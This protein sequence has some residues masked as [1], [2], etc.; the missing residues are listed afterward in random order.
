MDGKTCIR[1]FN[2]RIHKESISL[3]K[4]LIPMISDYLT[5]NNIDHSADMMKL[6]VQNPQLVQ[7]TI[8]TILD[9]YVRKYDIYSI[10]VGSRTI[11]Y[12]VTIKNN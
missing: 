1:V 11:L 12:Y 6:I 4:E 9:Y 10:T 3:K 8:P 2:K 7:E 5:E